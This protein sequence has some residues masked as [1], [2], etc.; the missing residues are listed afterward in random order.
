M[1]IVNQRGKERQ[2]ASCSR[3]VSCP[4][5]SL[6]EAVGFHIKLDDRILDTRYNLNNIAHKT[7]EYCTSHA[8]GDLRYSY[9]ATYLV[10]QLLLVSV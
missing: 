1:T 10:Y 2:P 8:F 6:G 3:Q 5:P 9:L 4:V 7:T